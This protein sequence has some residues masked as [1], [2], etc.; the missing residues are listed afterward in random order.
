MPDLWLPSQHKSTTT[1]FGRYSLTF[2]L[3]VMV[4]GW[5]AWVA[6]YIWKWYTPKHS[7]VLVLLSLFSC[8][9]S[10]GCHDWSA[11]QQRYQLQTTAWANHQPAFWADVNQQC[12]T[13]FA[14]LR[15]H[16][17]QSRLVAISSDR[18]SSDS[19]QCRSDS[20]ETIVVEGAQN[21]V[22][23]SWYSSCSTYSNIVDG[24]SDIPLYQA[25]H[26][27]LFGSQQNTDAEH[28][29]VSMW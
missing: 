19:A 12:E 3:R 16:V 27:L 18:H 9:S 10:M 7:S 25:H 29:A 17:G 21:V 2:P 1:T 22:V 15:C 4:G 23:G 8:A 13:L 5:I 20:G 26:R 28:L 14:A 11:M 6:C 24:T